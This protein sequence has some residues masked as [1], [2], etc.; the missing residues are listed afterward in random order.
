MNERLRYFNAYEGQALSM[1]KIA[2]VNLTPAQI[3]QYV[4][5]RQSPEK[6]HKGLSDHQI[7]DKVLE[8]DQQTTFRTRFNNIRF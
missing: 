2:Q 1:A 5:V 7:L 3:D 4:D 8:S 6:E